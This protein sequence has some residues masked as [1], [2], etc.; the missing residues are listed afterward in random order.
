VLVKEPP[1]PE[2][3]RGVQDGRVIDRYRAELGN[4]PIPPQYS[5]VSLTP[6]RFEIKPGEGPVTVILNR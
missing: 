2:K 3:M 1:L 6:L 5:S 4:R